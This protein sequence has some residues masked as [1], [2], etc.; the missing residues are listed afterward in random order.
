VAA[1]EDHAADDADEGERE[2]DRGKDVHRCLIHGCGASQTSACD[3]RPL[4]AMQKT[5]WQRR[6]ERASR[7]NGA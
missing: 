5:R 3:G 2:S 1:F 4:Q 7:D 6:D